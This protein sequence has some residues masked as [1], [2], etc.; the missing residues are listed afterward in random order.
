[1]T[2]KKS[3][4]KSFSYTWYLYL[5]ALV[6]PAV[7]FP[8]SYSFMHRAKEYETLS[9]FLSCDLK[10]ENAEDILLK[11]FKKFGVKDTEFITSDV[12][13]SEMEFARKLSV[14]GYNRCDLLIIQKDFVGKTGITGASL[15]IDDKVKSLCKIDSEN[16]YIKD[17]KAYAVEL[18]ITSPL[19]DLA[20]LKSGKE[21]YAFINGKSYNIGDFSP[22][23]P[24]TENAFKLMQYFL[25]K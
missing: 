1:M 4:K 18:P 6:I 21:Y 23:K 2:F 22:R 25:G 13:A 10:D 12:N 17:K 8:L 7:A 5:I 14:V 11:K 20:K 16:L 3:F 15:E 9:I 19:S 24:T